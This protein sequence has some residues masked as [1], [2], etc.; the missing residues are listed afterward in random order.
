M[1]VCIKC[2]HH[3]RRDHQSEA[4]IRAKQETN[5]DWQRNI[6]GQSDHQ[7]GRC[8]DKETDNSHCDHPLHPE[9]VAQCRGELGGTEESRCV[10]RKGQTELHRRQPELLGIDKG[11]TGDEDKET[12]H[13]ETADEGQPQK[14][15]VGQQYLHA[16][17]HVP[18]IDRHP[19]RLRQRLGQGEADQQQADDSPDRQHQKDR[20]PVKRQNQ[21]ASGQR[22]EHW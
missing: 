8:E 18:D 3:R 4:G 1:P 11:R 17:H 2:Q 15:P 6:T 16:M 5:H 10:D 22:C 12:G 20:M 14:H 13:A 19:V 7:Q 9:P 21:Q